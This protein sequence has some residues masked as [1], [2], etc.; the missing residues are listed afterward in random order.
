MAVFIKDDFKTNQQAAQS[1]PVAASTNKTDYSAVRAE[2]ESFFSV[3]LPA[4]DNSKRKRVL[5]RLVHTL[6][7]AELPSSVV[8]N[9][10]DR[11]TA[12]VTDN[13]TTDRGILDMYASNIR[14]FTPCSFDE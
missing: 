11:P 13:R 14:N 1:Q 7:E 12:L 10:H 4:L 9:S 2:L 8:D 5:D 3:K 6:K